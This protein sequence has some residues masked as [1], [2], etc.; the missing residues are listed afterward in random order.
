M[1][2]N[3]WQL[4]KKKEKRKENITTLSGQWFQ[5]CMAIAIH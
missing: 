2:K 1:A 4:K 5:R 3:M